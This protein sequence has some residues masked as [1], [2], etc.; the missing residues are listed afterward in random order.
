MRT[1]TASNVRTRYFPAV[2]GL[3]VA[4]AM[5]GCT[6]DSDPEPTTDPT[7]GTTP[8]TT[9]E[10]PTDTPSASSE[11]TEPPEDTA[12]EQS[13]DTS[14]FTRDQQ[15]TEDFPATDT[16]SQGWYATGVRSAVHDGYERIVIDH[17]GSG[18]PGFLA[19][20]TT[21]AAAPGSGLAVDQDAPTY[22]AIHTVGLAGPQDV[23]ADE[24]LQNGYTV[25]DLN[26]KT[27]TGVT[28][29]LPFEAASSYYIGVDEERPFRVSTVDDPARLVIDIATD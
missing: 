14:E 21:E 7:S 6:S 15:E 25:T 1:I 20:Y 23:D 5:T 9:S 4:L 29:H 28:T 3:V 11:D 12:T 10:T 17:A 19:E 26:I 22:L 8:E 27:A 18:H 2:L 24:A 13:V 16:T